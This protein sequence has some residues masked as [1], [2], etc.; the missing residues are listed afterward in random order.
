M[1]VQPGVDFDQTDIHHYDPQA[2]AAL[3]DFVETQPRMGM[4]ASLS[5]VPEPIGLA[6]IHQHRREIA[7]AA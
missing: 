2:A 7:R 6:A 5:A 1:V 3:S 4:V